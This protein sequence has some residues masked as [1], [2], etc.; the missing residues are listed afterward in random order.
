M[1]SPPKSTIKRYLAPDLHKHYLVI[2]GV[3]RLQEI[4][5]NPRRISLEKFPA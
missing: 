3:N 1:N 2:G 4:L 5:L